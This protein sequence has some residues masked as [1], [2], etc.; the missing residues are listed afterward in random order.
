MAA[1]ADD[2][3]S[4]CSGLEEP[5][6]EKG[7]DSKPPSPWWHH[8]A[9]AYSLQ[10]LFL[11]MVAF[12]LTLQISDD[13]QQRDDGILF[14]FVLQVLAFGWWYVLDTAVWRRN[15]P[16]IP[17]GKV[18]SYDAAAPPAGPMELTAMEWVRRNTPQLQSVAVARRELEGR[19]AAAGGPGDAYS[20][21]RQGD[22]VEPQVAHVD[23][24]LACRIF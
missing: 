15:T 5:L 4:G 19:I 2:A 24:E 7:D 14:A 6:L 11:V 17:Y 3:A 10:L 9:V 20:I 23:F 21:D 18:L 12:G 8:R 13:A 16:A 1:G 22:D